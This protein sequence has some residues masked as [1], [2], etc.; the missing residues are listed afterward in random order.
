MKPVR[1][2]R[3]TRP[4]SPYAMEAGQPKRRE[5]APAAARP[6]RRPWPGRRTKPARKT[7]GPGGHTRSSASPTWVAGQTRGEAYA[8][9]P[10]RQGAGAEHHLGDDRVEAVRRGDA[11]APPKAPVVAKKVETT[12]PPPSDWRQS[13]GKVNAP[14]R[15]PPDDSG[16]ETVAAP[17]KAA[18]PHAEP[19]ADDPLKTPDN[20]PRSR[21]R[22]D[23][24]PIT[25]PRK[26]RPRCWRRWRWT[27]RRPRS[28]P[29]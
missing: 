13:W 5:I 19:R 29:R 15:R 9:V 14:L 6:R 22:G 18:L 1:R 2:R 11:S 27:S 16:T 23:S 8:G 25:P 10:G 20:S 26:R 3:R 12:M 21:K 7:S 4:T 17:P 24:P 28:G